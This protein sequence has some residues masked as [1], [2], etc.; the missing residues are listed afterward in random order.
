VEAVVTTL[1]E[2]NNAV[3]GFFLQ[4]EDTDADA[5]LLTSEGIFVYCGRQ[6]P[7]AL[8]AGQLVNVS[9]I[10]A[11]YFGMSQINANNKSGG[12]TILSRAPARVSPTVFTLPANGS[13]ADEA[14]FEFL[15]GMLVTHPKKLV[16]S[17]YF[18]LGR[19]GQL[20]LSAATRT[21]QFTTTNLPSIANFSRFQDTLNASRI[22]LDDLNND[23]NEALGKLDK[24]YFYPQGGLST[25]NYFR[26]GDSINDLTGV[27]HWSFSGSKGTNAWRIRPVPNQDYTFL[28][29]N[30]RPNNPASIAGDLKVASFNVLN[31]FTT[32]DTAGNVCGP[33]RLACRGADSAAEIHRQHSKIIAALSQ[34]NADIFVLVEIENDEGAALQSLTTALSGVTGKEFRMIDTGSIGTDAIKVGMLYNV[35]KVNPAGSFAI[36]N[37][38]VDSRFNDSRNRPMLAQAFTE[39]ASGAKFTIVAGHLKSKGSN[40]D[41]LGDRDIGDGQG[42][43]NKTRTLATQ[44]LADWLATD[45]THSGNSNILILGDFNAYAM[46]DPIV[47]MERAGYTNL[48][49]K[50]IGQDAYSYVFDGQL[51]YLDHALASPSLQTQVTGA[52]IWH[53]NADEVN[54]LDYND[55]I[56]DPSEATFERRS[57]ANELFTENP[58]RASDHDPIIVGLS[59]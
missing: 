38:D 30:P 28:P 10:P 5:D 51:G 3:E 35:D 7:A 21:H 43:C 46:E 45:P 41:N 2:K 22:I 11:E 37:S 13:T 8:S 24:P 53:I 40:C 15:E 39:L 20:V 50:I 49:Q 47:T 59:F 19:F 18:Q 33:S 44:A 17:E 23:Q 52:F 4:E 42:N 16:I 26:G 48:I 14:M 29:E 9:G 58:T 6:C 25:N 55:T 57:S 56:Q 32:I 12:I 54:L 34:L 31:Y 1:F 27:M 36:L